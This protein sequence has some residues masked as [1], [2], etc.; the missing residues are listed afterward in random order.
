MLL[1]IIYP[2]DFKIEIEPNFW[3]EKLDTGMLLNAH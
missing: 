3:T 2:L 1:N